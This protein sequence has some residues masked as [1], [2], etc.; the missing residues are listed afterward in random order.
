M[1]KREGEKERHF[2]LVGRDRE[3]ER[4]RESEMRDFGMQYCYYEVLLRHRAAGGRGREREGTEGR[5]EL[6][7]DS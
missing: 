2:R 7:V 3:K 6:R 1:R 4:E 5:K